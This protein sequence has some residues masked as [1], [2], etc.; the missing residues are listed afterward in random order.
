ME[1]F[2]C[3]DCYF[4]YPDKQVFMNHRQKHTLNVE[5]TSN[6]PEPSNPELIR[7]TNLAPSNVG[8]KRKLTCRNCGEC[9][10]EKRLLMNHRRD[11][12]P[13]D[14]KPCR[15]DLED[16]CSFEAKECW[17]RHDSNGPQT[18]NRTTRMINKEGGA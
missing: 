16:N 7:S 8:Q 18:V 1:Y 4:Q 5:P 3:M 12:H 10:T 14:R 13:L 17:Y 11:H 9:F 15:Y 6:T 2:K